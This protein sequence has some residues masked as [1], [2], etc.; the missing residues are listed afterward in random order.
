MQRATP[1]GHCWDGCGASV[2]PGTFFLPGHDRIAE[3]LVIAA[4]YGSVA[5]FLSAHGY[6]PTGEKTAS[7]AGQPPIAECPD[8]WFPKSAAGD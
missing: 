3:S 1:N 5:E 2:A 7:R 8:S 4:E 6:G